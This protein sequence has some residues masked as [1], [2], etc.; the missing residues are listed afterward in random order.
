MITN[1][2]HNYPKKKKKKKS[3]KKVKHRQN[4]QQKKMN[5]QT[6]FESISTEWP[7][8]HSCFLLSL[9]VQSLNECR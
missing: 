7:F 9:S 8:S 6:L 4:G 1:S 3:E 5:K 2:F